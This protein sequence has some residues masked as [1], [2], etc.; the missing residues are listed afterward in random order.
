MF[1]TI[2]TVSALILG[3]NTQ[4]LFSVGKKGWGK[5]SVQED[6]MSNLDLNQYEGVWYEAWR[7][8]KTGQDEGKCAFTTYTQ[9]DDYIKVENRQVKQNW[10][11]KWKLAGIDG[12]ARC[13]DSGVGNCVVSFFWFMR[14]KPT[15]RFYNYQVMDTDYSNYAIVYT[16]TQAWFGLYHSEAAWIISR[17]AQP[18]CND[19]D[20][21]KTQLG[22][23]GYDVST[24]YE[25]VQ[26]NSCTY[27]MA[28]K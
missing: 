7:E 23:Y 19:K 9:I 25:T 27:S 13:P 20:S 2:A 12:E 16:C 4:A 6:G 26:D 11:G 21:W 17:A 8:E 10:R 22:G 5:C 1:K 18:I 28:L 24:M 3:A 15:D 14:K